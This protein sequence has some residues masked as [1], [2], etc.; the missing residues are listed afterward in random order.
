LKKRKNIQNND[1]PE[2]KNIGQRKELPKLSLAPYPALRILLSAIPGVL[3]GVYLPVDLEW[4]L[5]GCAVTF[6]LMLAGLLHEKLKR[7]GTFPLPP[8]IVCYLFFIGFAFA[9]SACFRLYYAPKRSLIAYSGRQVILSG[10]IANRPEASGKGIG[11]LVDADEVFDAGKSAR[12]HDRCKV[13]IRNLQG[14]PVDFHYGDVVRVKGMLN[15]LPPAANRGEFS[16][17]D[18]ARMK[19]VSVQLFAAGPWQVQ[20]AGPARHDLLDRFV[21]LPVYG[22]ITSSLR[23]LMPEGDERRLAAGVLTGEKEFLP[24][25]VFE[26]FRITGTA[27]ILAVSGFNVG[28]LALVVHVAL[29]RLKVTKTGRWLSLILVL[30]ILLV[31]SRVTGNSPS[32]N[33]AAIMAA[34]FAAG[35]ASGRKSYPLNSLA[36]SDFLIL[37]FDPLDLL[38]PGF[39]MTNSAVISILLFNPLFSNTNRQK[40][41][42]V[43]KAVRFLKESFLVTLAAIIGVSPVIAYYF[44]TFSLISI[45]ANIPVVFF[46][47]LLMYALVPMLLA[48]LASAYAASLFAES[49]FLFARLTLASAGFFSTVPFASI[50]LKPGLVEIIL[51]YTTLAAALYFIFGKAW[52]KLAV[53]MLLGANLIFWYSFFRIPPE[54]PVVVTVNLGRNIAAFYTAGNETLQIDA[55]SASREGKR[56]LRQLGEYGLSD[57]AAAVQFFSADS[58]IS[59][60]RAKRHMLQR[61]SLLVLPSMVIARPGEKVLKILSRGRSLLF[62]SGMSRLKEEEESRADI[63]FLWIYR[64]DEKQ[65]AQLESWLHFVRPQRCFLIPG[66]FLSRLHLHAL[67]RFAAGHP[68]LE[69]RSKTRQCIISAMKVR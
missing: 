57:P 44:G 61:D 1:L 45:I 20:K 62:V 63:V 52:G 56:I 46:S 25:E 48:N 7:R 69:I 35:Q 23:N 19:Q 40:G 27:H 68:N 39:L 30:F 65:R 11:M 47:T 6:S 16:P 2:I 33:R 13:F 21:V 53:S 37:L 24:E 43:S 64:F 31:Y 60:V 28:L 5:G 41:G 36:F 55:G 9:S 38:N 18:A 3:A 29:Q 32:V 34:V 59:R 50:T 66:S 58:V 26:E 14:S 22:Y 42:A 49:A 17:R 10:R 15:N 54:P 67:Q 4:W 8:T 12:L 51:Y